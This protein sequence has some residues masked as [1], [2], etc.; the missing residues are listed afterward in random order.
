MAIYK[1]ENQIQ[2]YAWGSADA[3]GDLLGYPNPNNEPMA[4]LWMGAHPK[5]PSIAIDANPQS[6]NANGLPLNEMIEESPEALLG[7]E[8]SLKYGGRLPFLFKVLAA[9]S[10]L[11]IQ[12]HPSLDEAGRGF[13]RENAAGIALDALW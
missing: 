5:S 13:A 3:M 12:A 9:A 8:T 6:G 11:S 4:E 2:K 10:P 1:L 7:P